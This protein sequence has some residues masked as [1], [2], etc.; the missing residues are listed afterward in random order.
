[1]FTYC[2][3]YSLRLFPYSCTHR[4]AEQHWTGLRGHTLPSAVTS[5]LSLIFVIHRCYFR[6]ALHRCDGCCFKVS[7]VFDAECPDASTT[8]VDPL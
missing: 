7:L 4:E 6:R 5:V 2:G 8:S 3:D 1:M